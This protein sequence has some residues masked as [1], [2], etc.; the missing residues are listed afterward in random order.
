[1]GVG[2][3]DEE[4]GHLSHARWQPRVVDGVAA[5]DFLILVAGIVAV[6]TAGGAAG[7][8]HKFYIEVAHIVAVGDVVERTEDAVHRSDGQVGVIHTWSMPA[9]RVYLVGAYLLTQQKIG[10]TQVVAVVMLHTLQIAEGKVI[11]LDAIG[12]YGDDTTV[13]ILHTHAAIVLGK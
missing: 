12:T 8:G 6:V 13:G 5:Y 2:G 9:H 7:A 11:S 10:S 1:M 3:I 4:V